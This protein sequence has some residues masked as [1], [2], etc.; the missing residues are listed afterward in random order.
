MLRDS[1]ARIRNEAANALFEL[2][3]SPF[4]D[5]SSKNSSIAEFAAEMLSN[6]V[7]FSLNSSMDPLSGFHLGMDCTKHQQVK[8]VLG[9]YLFDLANMLFALKSS[10]QLVRNSCDTTHFEA[11]KMIQFSLQLGTTKCLLNTMKTFHPIQFVDIWC[12]YNVLEICIELLTSNYSTG[13]DLS[14]QCD[15]L[16][17]SSNLLAGN[18]S[19]KEK[20]EANLQ[21]LFPFFFCRFSHCSAKVSGS[22][23]AT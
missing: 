7:P 16:T 8:R 1:D 4:I 11:R 21:N 14:C 9:K 19:L 13:T 3:C 20:I 18:Y 10:E 12:E 15:L 23:W 6:E 22:K 17:I 5:E 2:N